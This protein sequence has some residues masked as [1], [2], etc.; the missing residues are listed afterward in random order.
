MDEL[1]RLCDAFL[2]LPGMRDRANRDL[3]V[4]AMGDLSLT[5]HADAYH[6]VWSLLVS[7][8]SQRDGVTRLMSVVNVFHK[9]SKPMSELEALIDFLFPDALLDQTEREQLESLLGNVDRRT[10]ALAYRQ[11]SPPAWW[12]VEFDRGDVDAVVRHLETCTSAEGEPP[13]LL[14]FVDCVAHQLDSGRLACHRW[15]DAVGARLGIPDSAMARLCTRTAEWLADAEEPCYVTVGLQPDLI[16]PSRFLLSVWLQHN[17]FPAE[18]LHRD[19]VSRTLPEIPVILSRLLHDVS[20]DNVT[21][22]FVLPR[23][24]LGHPIDQ[25]QIDQD[26]FPH[27]IGT[28]YPVVVRSLDRMRRGDLHSHWRRKWRWVNHN[29]HDPEPTALHWVRESD[30][31][32]SLYSMLLLD[33]VP[34]AVALTSPPDDS[35][36]LGPD[37][38]T[39]ALYAGVPI[40]FWCRNRELAEC[41]ER[42]MTARLT[43][44]GVAELPQQVLRLRRQVT[45]EAERPL[46]GE[47]LT[48]LW[49]DADRIPESFTRSTRLRAPR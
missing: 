11:A 22:E 2:R 27:R 16:D 35:A 28:R 39:A 5:R 4:E 14:A 48:L 37:V 26:L 33:N 38:L 36:R 29:G 12:N 40:V 3:Y 46:L 10:L 6:D 34:V 8:L 17:R 41:F 24:L 18:P 7:C 21:I 25:W 47:H 30:T 23:S 44:R 32:D 42:D 45:G 43:D 9:H 49:D 20:A 19:D 13:P 15:L 31:P 1:E